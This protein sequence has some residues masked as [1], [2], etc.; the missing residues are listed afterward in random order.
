MCTA[1]LASLTQLQLNK[2]LLSQSSED[3]CS[4]H[5][6]L[7]GRSPGQALHL[8]SN[9]CPEFAPRLNV[10]DCPLLLWTTPVKAPAL[11]PL[12]EMGGQRITTGDRK[13][14][15]GSRQTHW[16]AALRADQPS[17]SSFILSMVYDRSVTAENHSPH[18]NQFR[19][20]Q[21]VNHMLGK[22]L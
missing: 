14:N 4:G 10:L 16:E 1:G 20:N 8:R 9:L 21:E 13:K 3:S 12:A 22:E 6:D 5:P 2:R 11:G 15:K 7:P 17:W 19:R 18:G